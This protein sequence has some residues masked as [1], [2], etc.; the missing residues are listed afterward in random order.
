[1]TP[2]DVSKAWNLPPELADAI[3]CIR[4]GGIVRSGKAVMLIDEYIIRTGT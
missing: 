1:M 4:Y 3:A 2:E